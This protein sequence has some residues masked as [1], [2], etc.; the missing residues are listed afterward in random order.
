LIV[1]RRG[2]DPSLAV[3]DEGRFSSLDGSAH[4]FGLLSASAFVVRLGLLRS[5]GLAR[6]HSTAIRTTVGFR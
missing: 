4:I 3:A 5:A 6:A 2:A 1:I